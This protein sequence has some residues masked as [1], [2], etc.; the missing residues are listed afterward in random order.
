MKLS[1]PIE[2]AFDLFLLIL[3]HGTRSEDFYAFLAYCHKCIR[4]KTKA[5]ACLDLSS[6]AVTT[7]CLSVDLRMS[8]SLA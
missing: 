3:K 8:C 5:C 7:D 6:L 2:L 1:T 4:A